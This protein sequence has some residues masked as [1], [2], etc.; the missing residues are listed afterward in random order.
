MRERERLKIEERQA[1]EEC[2]HEI[3]AG[4]GAIFSDPTYRKNLEIAFLFPGRNKEKQ[5]EL[6][7]NMVQTNAA[8]CLSGEP[9]YGIS[10]EYQCHVLTKTVDHWAHARPALE[11]AVDLYRKAG[12][13]M[14]HSLREWARNPGEAPH[15]K[16]GSHSF[17]QDWKVMR[18]H[19]IALAIDWAAGVQ[20]DPRWPQK[21]LIG[22]AYSSG[23]EWRCKYSICRAVLEALK[24]R[25]GGYTG[26]HLPTYNMIRNAWQRY[27]KE[28]RAN[29][30]GARP[31]A[32]PA[33]G[34]GACPEPSWH[35]H[36]WA[37]ANVT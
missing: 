5:D 23:E 15:K 20:Q 16:R 2:F 11:R 1:R 30:T 3:K 10:A 35:R 32:S 12:K 36:G 34:V 6:F 8:F 27:R 19:I 28:I 25:Y 22:R 24:E 17:A 18:D 21:L 7:E 26:C 13:L 4:V 9:E 29:G 33:P 31:A 37:K 14:P